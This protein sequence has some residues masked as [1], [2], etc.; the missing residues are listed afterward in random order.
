M[1]LLRGEGGGRKLKGEHNRI[2]ADFRETVGKQFKRETTAIHG[3][4]RPHK[5]GP[6]IR[7]DI[8]ADPR[9]ELGG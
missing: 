9:L 8:D 5:T 4:I 1:C 3:L 2:M 6:L 7:E